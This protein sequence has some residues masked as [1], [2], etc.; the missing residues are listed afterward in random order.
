[1]A[2]HSRM[3]LIDR[4]LRLLFRCRVG[5]RYGRALSRLRFA[6]RSW[7]SQSA[8]TVLSFTHAAM[9]IPDHRFRDWLWRPLFLDK[10][11]SARC[12]ARHP[13]TGRSE[14]SNGPVGGRPLEL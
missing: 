14:C 12:S 7:R 4:S 10:T 3:R 13:A 11:T 5:L 8:P 9:V 1:M 2:L 6:D